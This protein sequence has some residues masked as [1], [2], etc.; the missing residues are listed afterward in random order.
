MKEAHRHQASK[1]AKPY[2]KHNLVSVVGGQIH[3]LAWKFMLSHSR[4]LI[5]LIQLILIINDLFTYSKLPL[6]VIMF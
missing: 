6:I 1:R 5:F 4:E 2:T 3:V